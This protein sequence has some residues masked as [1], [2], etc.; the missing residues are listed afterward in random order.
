MCDLQNSGICLG[1]A[2][3]KPKVFA[4][5]ILKY[6]DIAQYFSF[7]AGANL[8]GSKTRK[9]EVISD[10]LDLCGVE[11]RSLIVMVGDRKYDILGAKKFDIDSIWS[12]VWIWVK[13]RTGK[14]WS[15][16]YCRKVRDIFSIVTRDPI[17]VDK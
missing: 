1:V 14:F 11:N 16:L 5:R 9:E 10:A 12:I 2:T 15:N 8:D 7:I 3:S 4:E 13:R 6:F 17:I